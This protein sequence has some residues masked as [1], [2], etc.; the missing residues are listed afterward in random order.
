MKKNSL[1]NFLSDTGYKRNSPDVNRPL[2]VIPSGRITMQDVDFPVR[3]VDNLGNEM[4]MMPGGEYFF[5]GDYVV[6]TPMMQRGGLTFQPYYT[7]AAESTGAN[8]TP[9]MTVQAAERLK[10]QRDA[11][12]LARRRQA[13][14]ASQAAA[15]RSFRE[16]LTPENLAQET[17]ATGDKLRF[18]PNDPN[19]FI[20]DYLNPL[21]MVG[22]R[23]SGL[24][25]LP[26]NVKQ[27]NYGAAALDVAI[28]VATGALA[29]L[30]AKSAG[31]FVNN[32]ANPLAGTGQFLT[33]QTPLK[34]A[35]KYNPW[36]FK[37]NVNSAYRM[38][39]DERG[40]A[41]ALESGYLQPSK[42]GSDIGRVHNET[43]YQIG[44]PSDTREYFGRTWDRGYKGPYMVEVPNATT[45]IRFSYG[46]SGKKLGSGVWTYPDDYIPSSEAKFYKEDWLKGYKEVPKQLPGSPNVA[47]VVN[48]AKNLEDLKS[49]Q[50]FAQQYGYELPTNIERIAQSNQLTD[51]TIRGMMNRHNT[52]VRGVST[53]WEELGK[54]N[55]EIL[56][57][58][59][60]KGFDLSTKEGTQAA[61]EYM[62]THIPINTG[63]GRAS[64]NNEVFDR[65]MEGLYTSNS[66]P[67]AEGYT[68]GQGY[69]TKVKRPTNYSSSNR[70]D[71]ISQN[72]PYYRDEDEFRK[73][74]YPLSDEANYAIH[75]SKRKS[76]TPKF[77]DEK[78]LKNATPKQKAIKEVE[79]RIEELKK[80]ISEIE[81]N[82]DKFVD[83]PEVI[84]SKKETIKQLENDIKYLDQHGDKLLQAPGEF[85]IL[86]T[87]KAKPVDYDNP[88]SF[89]SKLNEFIESKGKNPLSS[90]PGTAEGEK[91]YQDVIN[92]QKSNLT[93]NKP[94]ID[95]LRQNHPDFFEPN[96]YAHYIH[97]GTPGEK[98]LQPIKSWEITPEIWKNKSR[99]H[100]NKYS[101]RFSAM[102]VGGMVIS[103]AAIIGAGALQE[104]P[105]YQ[106]GDQQ[107]GTDIL[108]KYKSY[109]MGDYKPEEE[110]DL[111]N[112]YDKLNRHY[113]KKA[114]ET[115]KS[116]PNYIMSL[117]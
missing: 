17:G 82:K 5:P 45:D 95:Y 111:K 74:M 48:T 99:S 14:Q 113:Y 72:N 53:N 10:A 11:Q 26:L 94:V 7:P 112:T 3:G 20:D 76:W 43:H 87:E 109:I 40:L 70:Q 65:G 59:E 42:T 1:L 106:K 51:R 77:F 62:A 57:H 49:A 93:D 9:T 36:A 116:V 24:G 2:N 85:K 63:Y 4:F 38:I 101:K 22:D 41:S 30:G 47:P 12:E 114:K 92:L 110:K 33:T 81:P 104:T 80:D 25:R 66:I 73:L 68:Y 58:L 50:Q 97:L 86:R 52:F 6:E 55:P 84:Y 96:K 27:G 103:P 46:P 64:L 90:K 83:A 100:T 102:S 79:Y 54:R 88:F 69:I 78:S 31:Q 28:L 32:L 89:N 71:W 61:A 56:R 98:V 37:P 75:S 108:D 13:I 21:K 15:S 23:A 19:S 39:G 44:A 29:G 115:G 35:Y 67:T 18:F 107:V 16:R 117:L 60:G 34:N 8:Y 105:Q 91:L